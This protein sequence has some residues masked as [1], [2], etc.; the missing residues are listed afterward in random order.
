[1]FGKW[2]GIFSY[3]VSY[4]IVKSLQLFRYILKSH[5]SVSFLREPW[6]A[7]F[8]L[9]AAHLPPGSAWNTVSINEYLLTKCINNYTF[10]MNKWMILSQRM[11]AKIKVVFS[12]RS[13]WF[14]V[15]WGLL[16]KL[17]QYKIVNINRVLTTSLKFLYGFNHHTPQWD[18][19]Y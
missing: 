19:C 2:D 6:E 5:W 14:S 8:I 15:T 16:S 13:V 1:M 11:N 17:L 7:V 4:V 18:R 12:E 10:L 3:T 9:F